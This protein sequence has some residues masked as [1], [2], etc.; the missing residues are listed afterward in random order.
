MPERK[1]NTRKRLLSPTIT[2][3]SVGL[4]TARYRSRPQGLS[5][6]TSKVGYV[7]DDKHVIQSIEQKIYLPGITFIKVLN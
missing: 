6:N 7:M 5:I 2:I 4:I 3:Y 1:K